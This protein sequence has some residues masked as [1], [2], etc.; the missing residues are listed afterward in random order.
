[1]DLKQAVTAVKDATNLVDLIGQTVKLRKTGGNWMG[2]CPIH[3]GGHKSP[4]LSVQPQKGQWHCF[5]CQAGGDA[6]DWVQQTQHM[7]WREA[8]EQLAAAAGIEIPKD[9]QA[10]RD[11][12]EDKMLALLAETQAF[13]RIRLDRD[14]DALSYLYGRDLTTET[15]EREGLGYAPDGWDSTI[16]HL[17]TAGFE[18]DLIEAA[19]VAA[20]SQ[21]GT[22]IDMLRDRI[23]I[24][25]KDAR[26]RVIAFG[27]R[28]LHGEEGPK[29]LNTRET[30]LF[31]KGETLFGLHGA[32]GQMKEGAVIVEG[33]FDAIALHQAGLPQAVAPLG[34]AL[35]EH[36]LKGLQRWTP[37]IVLAFDGDR[38]GHEATHKA[39]QL[40]I[41]LGME[42][43]LL[44]I[45]E[46]QDPDTW[47]IQQGAEK[48][49][50]AVAT[51]P[52]WAR[53]V[54]E[55]ATVGRDLRRLEDRL[56]AARQ[57]IPWIMRLPKGRAG[58]MAELA[59]HELK[60][61]ITQLRTMAREAAK[62]T[63]KAA[64]VAEPDAPAR[65]AVLDST[66]QGLVGI[67]MKG[68]ASLEWAKAIPS[69]WWED[70]PGA[71]ALMALLE[72]EGDPEGL[73]DHER[74]AI[75]DAEARATGQNQPHP[76][77][78]AARLE[79]EFLQREMAFLTKEVASDQHPTHLI[80]TYQVKL[81]EIR[82]RLA[83]LNRSR[84]AGA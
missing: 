15:I 51:A 37:R 8:L 48:A 68:G 16:K 12:R 17:E 63:T 83:R 40:A 60:V 53:F 66:I 62:G 84:D 80:E 76:P 43:R 22:L 10:P 4:C 55:R 59:A 36:H 56:E 54:L 52:D 5:Q 71:G 19:G 65:P 13:Y 49:Q 6:I 77:R 67:A 70:K 78:L 41:P 18:P 30:P 35:T 50:A 24:P 47:A 14:T 2:A 28:R 21:R 61:P 7:E 39:L 26:G 23:T 44:P 42:V 57:I 82:G 81:R 29:Y 9:R 73:P 79:R 58:D 25:I 33:Y 72:N 3:G 45:P 74:L 20:R 1:M 32:K 31:R 69:A 38:A 75:R 46:G 34:T 11:T 64:A 27:G